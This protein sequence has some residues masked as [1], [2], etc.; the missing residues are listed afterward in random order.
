MATLFKRPQPNYYNTRLLKEQN[1][2]DIENIRETAT[3]WTR[4]AVNLRFARVFIGASENASQAVGICVKPS[5]HQ[6]TRLSDQDLNEWVTRT[7]RIFQETGLQDPSI[8][9]YILANG[10][11]NGFSSLGQVEIQ[12][13]SKKDEDGCSQIKLENNKYTYLVKNKNTVQYTEECDVIFNSTREPKKREKIAHFKVVSTITLKDGKIQ[14]TCNRAFLEP[15]PGKTQQCIRVFGDTRSFIDRL[16]SNI[17][18]KLHNIV[19]MFLHKNQ[20]QQNKCNL[21]ESNAPER[22]SA[23]PSFRA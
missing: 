16:I 6:G 12:R 4:G 20:S 19:N 21:D 17:A 3:E 23:S 18:E 14:H 15:Y 9:K 11:I 8:T 1:I 7:K 5:A 10:N 13:N 22:D 2:T